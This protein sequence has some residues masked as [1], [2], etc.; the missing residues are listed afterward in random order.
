MQYNLLTY[1]VPVEKATARECEVQS[2]KRTDDR[3][4]Q[5]SQLNGIYMVAKPPCSI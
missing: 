1:D 4:F 3:L 2:R 5:A